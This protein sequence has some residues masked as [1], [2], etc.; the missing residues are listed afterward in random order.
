MNNQLDDI[1]TKL[2]HLMRITAELFI[3]IKSNSLIDNKVDICIK[4]LNTMNSSISTLIN[5]QDRKYIPP[6]SLPP[7][8]PKL[9]P[10]KKPVKNNIKKI[11]NNGG[12]MEELKRKLKERNIKNNTN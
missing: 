9:P 6:P 10:Y 5:N 12:Y 1:N 4:S 8:G 11:T 7:R 3:M 2:D